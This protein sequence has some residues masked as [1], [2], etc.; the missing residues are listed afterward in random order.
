MFWFLTIFLQLWSYH[1]L[2]LTINKTKSLGLNL[3]F[4]QYQNWQQKCCNVSYLS[5]LWHFWDGSVHHVSTWGIVWR[6]NPNLCV[7]D[8]HVL[9]SFL[10][11]HISLSDWILSDPLYFITCV[12]TGNRWN[13]PCT[14]LCELH[15]GTS[16]SSWGSAG[17]E[18]HFLHGHGVFWWKD[19]PD[20]EEEATWGGLVW[21]PHRLC[22]R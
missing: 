17:V 9:L 8:T 20:P 15:T 13:L 18:G 1:R 6:W 4:L 14:S 12:S 19:C 16:A 2:V 7:W 10:V 22:T 5:S 3:S 11:H 21:P